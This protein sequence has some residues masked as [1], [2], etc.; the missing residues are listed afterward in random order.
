MKIKLHSHYVIHYVVQER[1]S[2]INK[3]LYVTNIVL[4]LDF[5][6]NASNKTKIN[7]QAVSGFVFLW[8]NWLHK[9]N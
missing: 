4:K 8:R 9:V 6:L 7:A 2:F 3:N 1:R 5:R